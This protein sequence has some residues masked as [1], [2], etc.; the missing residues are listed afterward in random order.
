VGHGARCSILALT[1]HDPAGRGAEEILT[2]P[3]ARSDDASR[4][5]PHERMTSQQGPA[6]HHLVCS[7]EKCQAEGLGGPRF[8]D[9]LELGG[10]L[11][12]QVAPKLTSP[13]PSRVPDRHRH[14]HGRR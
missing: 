2:D 6:T 11:D 9:Q 14:H 8:D 5:Q 13:L 3:A 1:R 4:I 12:G 7:L 10:L